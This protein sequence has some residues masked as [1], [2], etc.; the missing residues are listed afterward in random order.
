MVELQKVRAMGEKVCKSCKEEN[1]SLLQYMDRCAVR[2]EERARAHQGAVGRLS[3]WARRI[4]VT[5]DR[6]DRVA[7][8]TPEPGE[9]SAHTSKL[10]DESKQVDLVFIKY[11]WQI[12]SRFDF[13]GS[14]HVTA[15]ELRRILNYFNI[16]LSTAQVAEV[17]AMFLSDEGEVPIA[18]GPS[19]SVS[20]SSFAALI[21]KID[22]YLLGV[23]HEKTS[24][25]RLQGLPCSQ[26]CDVVF[27]IVFPIT[28]MGQ[29]LV[30]YLMLP[31]Y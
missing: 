12:F 29:V 21:F 2:M 1:M 23:T 26:R 6:V 25:G 17:I 19:V 24:L 3:T 9:G 18:D 7:F 20:F 14:G 31:W 30:F 5:R 13:D 11:T 16:Y 15:A 27:R 4:S 28:I 10:V 22:Q 8:D